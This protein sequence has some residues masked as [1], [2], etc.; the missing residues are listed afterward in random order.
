M[1]RVLT[2]L[3][4]IA[5][6][7][8]SPFIAPPFASAQAL[9]ISEFI[10][11]PATDWDASG[12]FSSRDDEWVELYNPGNEPVDLARFFLT[13]GD[14]IP[15]FGLAGLLGARERL[16]VTGKMSV[17]WERATGH[18][19]FGLSLG[20]TG[21]SVLLWEVS[22]PDTAL[23]DGYTYRSHEAAADR[24]VGRMGDSGAWALF[25]GLN[26]YSGTTPPAGTGCSPSINAT[27]A[28]GVT[29]VSTLRWGDLKRRYR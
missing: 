15:R 16:V 13:D 7:L 29:P 5:A 12:A 11:G 17:D 18:P 22:G 27:N 3:P 28:C 8:A 14:S 19:V 6:V 4:L 21:D 2:S 25:D 10:A 24:A 23:A 9:L 1:R 26:P 20:N